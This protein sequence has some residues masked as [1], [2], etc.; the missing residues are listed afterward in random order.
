VDEVRWVQGFAHVPA[1][2]FVALV[3]GVLFVSIGG[4][5]VP[6]TAT[7]L[8]AG[9]LAVHH[10]QAGALLL[11]LSIAITLVV[12]ARDATALLLG[13]HGARFWRRVTDRRANALQSGSGVSV[14]RPVARAS[15][16][17]LRW[18]RGPSAK[19]AAILAA[20]QRLLREQ[21]AVVLFLTRLTPLASPFDLAA[22]MAGMS[23]RR[24]LPP[25]IAGRFV[26]GGM[27]LAGG[28]LFGQAWE[29]SNSV[30]ELAGI[31]SIVIILL[32]VLPT[33]LGQRAMRRAMQPA[34]TPDADSAEIALTSRDA[35]Y[36]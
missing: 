14:R 11:A 34:P 6:M 29:H 31:I 12:S 8:V 7:V 3:A 10:A 16:A 21:G 20:A 33:V 28:A 4:F 26:W 25:I 24:F 5:P 22:G 19:S 23:L 30:P 27:L 1:P 36:P 17:R 2:L 18:R 32:I 9:A 13:R 35:A 15:G